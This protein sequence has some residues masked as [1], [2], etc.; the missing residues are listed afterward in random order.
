MYEYYKNYIFILADLKEFLSGSDYTPDPQRKH[1]CDECEQIFPSNSALKSH[2]LIDH[3]PRLENRFT[4]FSKTKIIFNVIG[5]IIF[6]W[7]L[8]FLHNNINPKNY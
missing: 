7:K 1:S 4:N 5:R 8:I 3:N 6:S 2:K